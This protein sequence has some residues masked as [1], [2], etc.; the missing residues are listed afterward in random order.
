MRIFIDAN[1]IEFNADCIVSRDVNGFA[2][3]D[4]EVITPKEFV[5]KFG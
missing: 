1:V 3:D 5:K 4:I 2:N